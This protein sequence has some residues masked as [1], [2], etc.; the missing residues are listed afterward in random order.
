M[1]IAAL[2][3]GYV[4]GP[5][6]RRAVASLLFL[7]AI[8]YGLILDIDSARSGAV[9]ESQRPMEEMRAQLDA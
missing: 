3:L 5:R 6:R 4:M 7:T 1:V 8:S 2:V 9:R